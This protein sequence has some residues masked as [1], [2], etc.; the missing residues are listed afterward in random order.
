MSVTFENPYDF[1]KHIAFLFSQKGFKVT[2]PPANTKGYDIEL[3]RGGKCFAVQ[4]KNHK[5]KV[6]VASLEKFQ[7]FLTSS[8]ADK[9][10]TGYFV[11]A[12]GY[13]KQAVT[14]IRSEQGGTKQTLLF[15]YEDGDLIQDHPDDV[16]PSPHTEVVESRRYFGVFTC[17]GGVG[18]TT[19]AAHLAGAFALMGYDVILLDLDPDKNLRKLFLHDQDD[20]AG[21][22]SLYVPATP[23]SNQLGATITVLNH[24]DWREIDYPDVKIVICDCS[25]VLSENPRT[26]VEKFDYCIIPTTLNPLGIAKNSDV[27]TRT[28]AHI[29]SWNKKAS[30]FALINSFD[31]SKEAEKH[32]Q[33]LLTHL[34]KHITQ[35]VNTKQ[36]NLCFLIHPNNAK[37]RYSRA[38]L[39]WGYHIIDGSRPQLGFKE[40]GGRSYPRTDF[41]QLA[42]Y[43]E[44]HTNIESLRRSVVNDQ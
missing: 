18:K 29:R 22:A 23:K 11:S 12:S 4:V 42:E 26:L 9:F 36:D 10:D 44:D 13:S 1:E 31:A 24:E 27:I 20:E 19:T 5:A 32:N 15:T 34:Q 16:Y 6:N 30:L 37:I 14:F 40:A 17:K 43:L 2:L 39:N 41:L 25:P 7:D 38:L 28:F 8:L 35:Y 21:D 3:E 33:T